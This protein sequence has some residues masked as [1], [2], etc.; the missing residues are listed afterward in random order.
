M[1]RLMSTFKT[2]ALKLGSASVAACCSSM[3][4]SEPSSRPPGATSW[5]L[6]KA[7]RPRPQKATRWPLA[8]PKSRQRASHLPQL[9]LLLQRSSSSLTRWDGLPQTYH[10]SNNKLSPRRLQNLVLRSLCCPVDHQLQPPLL[11]T[12]IGFAGPRRCARVCVSVCLGSGGG[13]PAITHLPQLRLMPVV[14]MLCWGI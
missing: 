14:L 5:W 12:R 3:L 7:T 1:H 8:C 4:P 9:R 11:S 2:P 10:Q 6:P 13:L